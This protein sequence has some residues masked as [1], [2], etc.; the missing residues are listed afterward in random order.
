MQVTISPVLQYVRKGET[1]PSELLSHSFCS[2][3]RELG[4]Y[5]QTTECSDLEGTHKDVEVHLLCE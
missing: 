1:S 4:L 5:F 3:G 2:R